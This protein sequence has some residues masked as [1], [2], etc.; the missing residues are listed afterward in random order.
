MGGGSEATSKPRRRG[1]AQAV[2]GSMNAPVENSHRR[3]AP[4]PVPVIRARTGYAIPER[5]NH[6]AG[7]GRSENRITC[8][9][10]FSDGAAISTELTTSRSGACARDFSN[11]AEAGTAN[12]MANAA[13]VEGCPALIARPAS[14]PTPAVAPGPLSH[15]R[16][17][18]Q[19]A[20]APIVN[21]VPRNTAA[22]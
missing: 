11:P 19:P 6:S 1:G 8:G 13:R 18:N 20:A 16:L 9:Q 12:A 7:A 17:K 21:G 3:T 4:T 22:L 5:K 14:A 15:P 2:M 10:T